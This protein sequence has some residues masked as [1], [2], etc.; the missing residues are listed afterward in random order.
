MTSPTTV[1]APPRP[2]YNSFASRKRSSP[3]VK[4]LPE[5]VAWLKDIRLEMGTTNSIRTSVYYV[6]RVTYQPTGT[7][8]TNWDVKRTFD[9]YKWFQKRLLGHLQPKHSCKAECRWLNSTIKKHFPKPTLGSRYPPVV[10][11][12]RK[13]L[14]QILTTVQASVVNHGNRNCKVMLEA[15]SHEL[16]SFLVGDVDQSFV[17][18]TPPVTPTAS[19]EME[20]SAESRLSFASSVSSEEVEVDT[21]NYDA[22][23]F[24]GWSLPIEHLNLEPTINLLV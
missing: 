6:I 8:A 20:T 5:D 15:V 13:A 3:P 24:T 11:Q 18:V 2:V 23:T 17:G 1:T 10:E 16:S 9:E 4:P 22:D 7:A 12:R 21:I 14:L 19:S